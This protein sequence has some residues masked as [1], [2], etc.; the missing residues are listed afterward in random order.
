MKQVALYLSSRNNYSLLE[1]FLIRNQNHLKNYYLVNIDDFSEPQEREKG[2]KICNKYNI[3]FLSNRDRGLQNAGQ[4]MI[5]Y[6]GDKYS[7][8]LWLTHDTDFI[9]ENFIDKFDK[10][11]KSQKLNDF[12]LVGFNILGPQ[13]GIKDKNKINPLMCGMLGRAPLTNLPGRGSW[14]RIPDME[15]PWDIWG[16]E[17]LI[18][19]DAPVDMVVGINVKKFKQYIT[20]NNN[21]HLFCAFDDISM[22]F[23]NNGIYNV[24]IPT[25]QVWHDQRIKEGKIP[26]KSAH[27]AKQGDSKHFGNYGLHTIQWKSTWGWDRDNVRNTFPTK[28]YQKGLI[29]EFYDHDYKMGPLKIF[30]I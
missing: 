19:I 13:C 2:I 1:N 12:G 30:N 27:A 7:Y 11:V 16:G 15:L 29:R 25:L 17:N 8:I 24:C 10:L 3:P 4:T 21:Y 6:I 23:L 9:T 18:S 26:I 20:P 22:N 28:K 5:D 14:Y